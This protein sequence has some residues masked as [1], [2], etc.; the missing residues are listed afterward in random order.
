MATILLLDDS[1]SVLELASAFLSQS[2]HRVITCRSGKDAIARLDSVDLLVTDIYMPDED[3]LEVIRKVRRLR[4][5][6]PIL[7]MS[8]AAGDRNLLQVAR[9]L[10]ARLTLHKPFSKDDLLSAVAAALL[11][12]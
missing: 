4:P 5:D 11:R 2:D 9:H 7:A 6:L 8:G 1:R 10:G 12:D 3:G